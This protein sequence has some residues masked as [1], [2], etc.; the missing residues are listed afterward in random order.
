MSLIQVRALHI[1]NFGDQW[2]KCPGQL[3]QGVV[4]FMCFKTYFVQC[5]I[6]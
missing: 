3:V 1:Y 6:L 2:P 4:Y 5:Q